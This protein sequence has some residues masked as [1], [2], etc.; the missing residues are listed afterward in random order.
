MWNIQATKNDNSGQPFNTTAGRG[1]R[2][3]RTCGL[4]RL[5]IAI[6]VVTIRA[7]YYNQKLVEKNLKTFLN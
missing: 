4:P 7:F 5:D 1:E 2:I 6:D 3:V